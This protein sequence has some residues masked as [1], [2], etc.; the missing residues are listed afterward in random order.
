MAVEYPFKLSGRIRLSVDPAFKVS[1]NG[2]SYCK[3]STATKELARGTQPE[4]TTW[5][6]FISFGTVAEQIAEDFKKGDMLTAS[7]ISP[8]K[9]SKWTDRDGNQRENL[10]YIIWELA[11]HE[12]QG[13]PQARPP[14][15]DADDDIPF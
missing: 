9:I 4:T 7:N 14:I 10:E 6:N 1:A 13:Q 11:P 5:H 2:K 15:S 8:P 3:F 12:S